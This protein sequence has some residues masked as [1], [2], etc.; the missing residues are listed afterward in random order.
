MENRTIVAFGTCRERFAYWEHTDSVQEAQMYLG[1][2][3]I[4]HARIAEYPTYIHLGREKIKD[5]FLESDAK[6]SH[7]FFVDSDN[8]LHEQTAYR[9]LQHDLPI[10]SAL[11]F[12]R[13][14]SPEAVA[15]DF[16]DEERTKA[17]SVSQKI[18]DFFI[19]H[20]IELYDEPSCL[21]IEGSLM[22]VD[23]VGFGGVL[24]KREVLERMEEAYPGAVFGSDDPNIGEDVLFCRRAK[25]LGYPVYVDLAIQIGHLGKHIVT[26]HDFMRVD[27]WI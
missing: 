13:F 24:I 18:R 1:T 11:Y 20:K 8:V 22:Q 27:K 10:V 21:D 25:D 23:A 17:R 16:V 5:V 3:G 12:K 6:P 7:L 15:L 19:E 4:Y 9:L 2:K 14:G 26:S